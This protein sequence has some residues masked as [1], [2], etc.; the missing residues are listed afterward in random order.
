M[1]IDNKIGILV[2]NSVARGKLTFLVHIQ[3]VP[4]GSL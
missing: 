1:P 4:Y 3:I 2:L